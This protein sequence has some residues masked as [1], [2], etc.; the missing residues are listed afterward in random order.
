MIHL[1]FC[2]ASPLGSIISI[3]QLQK[4]TPSGANTDGPLFGRR[5]NCAAAAE[6][7][8][9]TGHWSLYGPKQHAA[10][11]VGGPLAG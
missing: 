10:S 1:A 2:A 3:P 8:R 7:K 6:L 11:Q 9:T 5:F 4:T